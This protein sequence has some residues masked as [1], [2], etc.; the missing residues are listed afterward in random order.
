MSNT[1]IPVYTN[2]VSAAMMAE[3]SK[4]ATAEGMRQLAA[5]MAE[6]KANPVLNPE[7]E[8]DS[9]MDYDSDADSILRARK[10]SR[11]QPKVIHVNG[12]GNKVL[13]DR[14]RFLQ[15]DL[16]NALVDVEDAKTAAD[17][18]KGQLA[19]IQRVNDELGFLK[20]AMLRGI[21]DSGNLSK[22]MLEARVKFFMEETTEHSALCLAS[23]NKIDMEEV[24][25][26]LMRVLVAEKKKLVNMEKN[27]KYLIFR[28]HV[29]EVGQKVTVYS[30]VTIVA[31][32]I[33]Y[34]LVICY[35]LS[36]C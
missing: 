25:A 10:R 7:D 8:T 13:E 3:Q 1:P 33:M 18:V 14:V 6:R 26:G 5:A 27:Y 36:S 4:K 23:L 31:L 24:K 32:A 28:A 22:V 21:K 30:S 29:L 15:L 12:G 16:T 20:S 19:P 11:H 35:F 2:H 34:Q 9:E 17:K